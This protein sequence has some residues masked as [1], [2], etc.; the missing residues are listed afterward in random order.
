MKAVV[1]FSLR[2]ITPNG[3]K[4]TGERVVVL[5]PDVSVERIEKIMNSLYSD[6]WSVTEIKITFA[7]EYDK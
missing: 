6:G 4:I 3:E 2:D 5:N 7:N 1:T